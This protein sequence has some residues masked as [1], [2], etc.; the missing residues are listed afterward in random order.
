MKQILS[1]IKVT[2]LLT[3][4]IFAVIALI[5]LIDNLIF[6]EPFQWQYIFWTMIYSTVF[7]LIFAFVSNERI[8]KWLTRGLFLVFIVLFFVIPVTSDFSN[9]VIYLLFSLFIATRIE[10]LYLMIKDAMMKSKSK[11]KSGE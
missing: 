9:H 5:G 7:V 6:S 4:A 2:L 11:V 3:Y 10:K 1:S 8:S